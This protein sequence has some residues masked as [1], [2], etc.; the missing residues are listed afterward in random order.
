[1]EAS[2][3]RTRVTVFERAAKIARE[4]KIVEKAGRVL[5]REVTEPR[6]I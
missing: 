4:S 1:M 3:S 2:R 6:K 5:S